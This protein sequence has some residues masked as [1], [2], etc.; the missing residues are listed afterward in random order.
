MVTLNSHFFRRL[1]L[2]LFWYL[3]IIMFSSSSCTYRMH[4]DNYINFNSVQSVQSKHT[5]DKIPKHFD[6][7]DRHTKLVG[8]SSLRDI[9]V[10]EGDLEFRLWMGFGTTE[11]QG[12]IVKKEGLKWNAKYLEEHQLRNLQKPK[13]GWDQ[14]WKKL[15]D[16]GM[17]SLPNASEIPNYGNRGTDG[18][19]IV[20]EINKDNHYRTYAYSNPCLFP[21]HTKCKVRVAEEEHLINIVKIIS[22]ELRK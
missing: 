12:Y 11:L 5:K 13:S 14:L 15:A 18:I 10:P 6:I 17:L 8:L 22:K 1:N 7:I 16:E 19:S 3:G 2:I 21:S 4:G 20:V 9:I